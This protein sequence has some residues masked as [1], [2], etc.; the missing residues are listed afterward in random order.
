MLLTHRHIESSSELDISNKHICVSIM[1]P[2]IHR[3]PPN[4][5]DTCLYVWIPTK[6]KNKSGKWLCFG[7]TSISG[8]GIRTAPAFWRNGK[9]AA[10]VWGAVKLWNWK[11]WVYDHHVMPWGHWSEKMGTETGISYQRWGNCNVWTMYEHVE[12]SINGDT[13]NGWFIIEHPIKMDDLWFGGT[14]I[15]G[16]PHVWRSSKQIW[17]VAGH[18]HVSIQMSFRLPVSNGFWGHIWITEELKREHVDMF[19]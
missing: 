18:G 19:R 1:V 5:S 14:P 7:Y 16:N 6:S 4:T 2:E 17:I 8:L 12:V 15:S 13:L 10:N 9:S 11:S 3:T